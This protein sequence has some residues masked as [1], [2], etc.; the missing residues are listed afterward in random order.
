MTRQKIGYLQAAI[1]MAQAKV[2]AC[3]RKLAI[4]STEEARAETRYRK[5]VKTREDAFEAAEANL[6]RAAETVQDIANSLK[7]E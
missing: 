2:A 3:R 4:T 6:D 1:I 7:G 5:A